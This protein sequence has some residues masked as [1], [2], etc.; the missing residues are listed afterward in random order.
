MLLADELRKISN[1]QLSMK[2]RTVF[3]HNI[4][5]KIKEKC[6]EAARQGL[7]SIT[8]EA[9]QNLNQ[10]SFVKICEDLKLEELDTNELEL[11]SRLKEEG[12]SVKISRNSFE[13]D[14]WDSTCST[15][16]YFSIS[17]AKNEKGW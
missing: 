14:D 11:Y 9:F 15:K 17:W 2:T 1:L 4:F 10:S 12:F 3:I 6:F 7:H 13:H 5:Q 8:I 16:T